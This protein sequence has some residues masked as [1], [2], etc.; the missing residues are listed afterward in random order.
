MKKIFLLATVAAA[1]LV[2]CTKNSNNSDSSQVVDDSVECDSVFEEY[3]SESLNDIRFENWAEQE[4]LDNDYIRALRNYLNEIIDGNI[5]E[6]N[7][8]PEQEFI[9]N[10][11]NLFKSKFVIA[12]VAPSLLGGLDIYFIF[13]DEP[14]YVF[15]SNVYSYVNEETRQITGYSV[16][17]IDINTTLDITKEEFKESIK[18]INPKFW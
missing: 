6:D 15:F 9:N 11:K 5:S 17:H 7:I 12:N 4:W 14:T 10:Y 13:P 2:S 1:L 16:R 3:Q 18:D 8:P